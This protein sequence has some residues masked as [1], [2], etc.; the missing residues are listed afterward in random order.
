[1]VSIVCK[2]AMFALG[3]KPGGGPGLEEKP[4]GGLGGDAVD[5]LEFISALLMAQALTH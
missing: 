3:E 1:M 5:L 2:R 4:G